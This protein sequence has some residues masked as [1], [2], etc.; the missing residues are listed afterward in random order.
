VPRLNALSWEVIRK[1]RSV[2]IA[3]PLKPVKPYLE[4]PS[5]RANAGKVVDDAT[6]PDEPG[7]EGLFQHLRALRKKLAD[8]LGLPPYIVFSDASLRAMARQ[9]PQTQE[10]FMRISGVGQKKMEAYADVFTGEIRAYCEQHDLPARDQSHPYAPVKATEAPSL[11]STAS[12]SPASIVTRQL[13]LA[14]FQQGLSI[15][16][17]AQRRNLGQRTIFTHL[18][19]LLEKGEQ[20]DVDRIVDAERYKVI[21]DA[22]Q[23]VDSNL[24]RPVKDYLGDDYSYEEIRLVSAAMNRV[25]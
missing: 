14:M 10:E 24:L 6:T 2:E 22:L 4:S 13:T 12:S 7:T 17:I 1:Q 25:G 5:R 3:A 21:A 8:E 15:A 20:I 19:E 16:E 18:T 23:H 9:R 11:S